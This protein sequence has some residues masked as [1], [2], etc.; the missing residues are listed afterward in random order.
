MHAKEY[1]AFI[2]YSHRDSRW[3]AWLHKSLEGYHP[4]KELVGT[5]TERGA[6]PK[7]LAPVFRDRDELASATD[8]GTLLRAALAGSACQVVVC[9]PAAA[10]SQWVNEEI[11]QFKRLGREDRIFCLIVG[12]EPNATDLPGREDEECFPHALRFRIGADGQLT[13]E[14]TEPIAADAR[15]GKD[16]RGNALL[17]LI[18]GLL[19]VGFD[20]LRRREQQRRYRRLVA[21]SV[22]AAGGM[23]LTSGLAA[24]ALIERAAAQRQTV[25]A[26]AEARTANLTTKFLVDLFRISDPSEA[27]GNTVTAREMLDKGAARVDSELASEPAIHARLLDT[28]GTVYMGLG[29]YDKARPL[30]D[31]A[32]ATRQRLT[33]RDPLELAASLS[34]SGDLL[35]LQAEYDKAEKAYREAIRIDSA[36]PADRASQEALAA[37]EYG[38]GTLLTEEGRPA[39]AATNLRNALAL[40]QSL[41]G[42]NNADVARTL[43]DLAMAIANGGDLN[44]AIPV[45]QQAVDMQRTLRGDEPH[46]DFAETLTD[47]GNLLQSHGEVAAEERY[48]REALAMKQRL[49]GDRHPEVAN[50][51]EMVASALQ[52]RH[53]FDEA[54]RLYRQSLEMRRELLGADHP[55][56]AHSV[57][58]LASLQFD[59]GETA[60]ALANAHEALR[61]FRKAYPPDHPST[62][63]ALNVIGFWQTE[64]GNY[65]DADR[66]I[67]EALAMRRRLFGDGQPDVASSLAVLA[68]LR[69]A[70]GRYPEALQLA[71]SAQGIYATSLG[72]DH[73]RTAFAECAAGGALAGLK[74]TEEADAALAHSNGILKQDVGAPFS[75]RKLA[76]H[77]LDDLHARARRKP[78]HRAVT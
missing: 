25:R 9:S 76:Q 17:K 53:Q 75:Y 29:L 51:L 56:V 20:A 1:R 38:L 63:F 39:D 35:M 57:F 3:A 10:K 48:F 8:L 68:V 27:R 26:E 19:G 21:F 52:D 13:T 37:A 6:V 41:Y 30:L 33:D 12:G 72:A 74:R 46:P 2:S 31:R 65:A 45:M 24:Y 44:A 50:G 62:A 60:L 40:Q 16:G 47:M 42:A 61:I 64:A 78:A 73:W 67:A 4:P 70:Q 69:N 14:R 43:K 66:D 59:R 49:L 5:V 77:Y 32:V 18:A 34:H 11:L 15:P 58:N 23:I 54:E 36:R 7:R 71:Q 28:L 22:A 55:D